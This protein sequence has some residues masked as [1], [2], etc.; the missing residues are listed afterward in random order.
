[1]HKNFISLFTI[2][3]LMVLLACKSER[4]NN[5]D[6]SVKPNVIIILT[7][8]QG[9]GDVGFNGSEEIPTPNIDRIAS[10][11]VKF[12]N[13]YVSYPVCGPSRAGLMTGRYQSRFGFGRN[14]ILAPQDSTMGLPLEEKTLAA[15][16]DSVGYISMAIGKWHLGAHESQHPLKRGFDEFYGFLSG[17]HRYFPE[18]YTLNDLSEIKGQWDGYLTKL[19]R[20][21]TRV[22]ETEYL[23]D[24]L[25]REAVSF[26]ERNKEN[27]FFLYLA[28]NAPHAPL[29]ATKK[30]LSRFEHI[31]DKDRRTYAAMVSAVDDG[32]GKLLNKLNEMNLEEET[33]VFFLSDNG[34]PE[35]HNSSDN[36]P[37]RAGKGSVFEGG[38]RIPFAVQWPGHLPA[39]SVYEKPVISLDMFA[40]AVALAGA[41]TDPGKPLDGINLMPY[42][43]G[44]NDEAPHD[45]LFWRKLDQQEY[46]VRDGNSG[47]KFVIPKNHQEMLFDLD[48]DL[49]EQNDISSEKAEVATEL[50]RRRKQWEKE[51]MDPIFMGLMQRDQYWQKVQLGTSD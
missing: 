27:P 8:D 41:P 50:N 22:E 24:A 23:T 18:E 7:D 19:L 5:P 12:T 13:G 48:K 28:Y 20:N 34:G 29:Q 6:K 42:L 39:G 51:L 17:G 25:S 36:G 31:E 16:L 47:M 33:L 35:Q 9:Y 14:P 44:R 40:T 21:H 38:V 26:V 30:Y 4:Q 15:V 3:L 46:A 11:G 43:T 1:M 37:L 10:N 49:S 32:V 45:Y 2:A